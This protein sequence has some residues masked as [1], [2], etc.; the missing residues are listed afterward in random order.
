MDDRQG[1]ETLD[2]QK[3]GLVIF[4]IDLAVLLIVY[5]WPYH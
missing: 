3:L 1:V 4:L 2:W 5:V